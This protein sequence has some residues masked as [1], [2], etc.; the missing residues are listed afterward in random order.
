[1]DVINHTNGNICVETLS[2][3]QTVE[4]LYSTLEKVII[5][6]VVPM[7][8]LIGLIGN[9]TF[10]Y[11]FYRNDSMRTTTNIYLG[12]LALAD[13]ILLITGALQWVCSY[14]SSPIYYNYAFSFSTS[15]GCAFPD[16]MV[17]LSYFASVFIVT[18]VTVER[19]LAV[20]KPVQQYQSQ[21]N[22]RAIKLLSIAWLFSVIL[23]A[24]R[25]PQWPV[26][27]CLQWPDEDVRYSD[28]PRT[29]AICSG[30]VEWSL[31]VTFY[32]DM[33]QYFLALTTVSFTSFTMVVQLNQRT[34][35][36]FTDDL[37]RIKLLRD[38]NKITCML[39]ANATIFFLCLTPFEILN[40]EGLLGEVS[41][42]RMSLKVS[43]IVAWVGRV[44][45]HVNSACNPIIYSV[46]HT[47]YRNAFLETWKCG[48]IKTLTS[49]QQSQIRFS[50]SSS[51][52]STYIQDLKEEHAF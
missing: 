42:H 35:K 6:F 25:L 32:T 14:A 3:V 31:Q 4:H 21:G 24:F 19:Y 29:V 47:R 46:I 22:K 20:C 30:Y 43:N 38:R 8:T 39:V 33:I 45:M 17:Y 1:M 27:Y 12:N 15:F 16:F 5:I 40:V 51:R 49:Y 52:R 9:C 26:T 48:S 34:M 13:S 44:L 7:I 36:T 23:A 2:S 50:V 37:S 18:I 28:Y 10:L 41:P 11:T